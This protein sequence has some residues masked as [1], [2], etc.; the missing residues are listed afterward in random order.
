[1]YHRPVNLYVN[2]PDLILGSISS[3][4]KAIYAQFHNTKLKIQILSF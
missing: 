3:K 4:P 2:S 1:M